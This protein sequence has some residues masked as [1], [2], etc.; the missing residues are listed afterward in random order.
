M[1]KSLK[2]LLVHLF[3]VGF[4]LNLI[5]ELPQCW[6]YPIKVLSPDHLFM[7]FLAVL[8]DALAV[9]FIFAVGIWMFEESY[10]VLNLNRYRSAYALGTGFLIGVVGETVALKLGWWSYGA[11]MPEIPIV[12]VGLSPVAQMT[13]LPYV[14]ILLVRRFLTRKLD[15]QDLT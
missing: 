3:W 2:I 13:L 7:L 12:N 15:Y 11:L 10:W 14:T 8:G 1:S 4:T 9:I 5:W 6:F